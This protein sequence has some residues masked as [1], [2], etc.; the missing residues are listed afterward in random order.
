MQAAA[1]DEATRF[2]RLYNLSDGEDLLVVVKSGESSAAGNG[3]SATSPV[4][5]SIT[6]SSPNDLVLHWGVSK[7]NDK[8]WVLP[9]KAVWNGVEGSVADAGGG[10]SLRFP[11]ACLLHITSSFTKET[12][13]CTACWSVV[14]HPF[15]L[16]ISW[17]GVQGRQLRPH[18]AH[19]RLQRTSRHLP[20][21]CHCNR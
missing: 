16:S 6:T 4:E 13:A 11:S 2:R 7:Q 1:V 8:S 3:A 19:A 5:V 17:A 21:S 12:S 10:H 18:S 15:H 14:M 20:P 9:P